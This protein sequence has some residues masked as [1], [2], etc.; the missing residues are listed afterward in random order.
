MYLFI[1]YLR[2]KIKIFHRREIDRKLI[3][4]KKL[5]SLSL[6]DY[7]QANIHMKYLHYRVTLKGIWKCFH[8]C[9]IV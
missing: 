6:S 9:S 8:D 4:E 7:L 3:R 1:N 2:C 5:L